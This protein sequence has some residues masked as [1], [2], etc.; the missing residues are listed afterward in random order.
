MTKVSIHSIPF[1][2]VPKFTQI[3]I[4]YTTDPAAFGDF[5]SF[6]P[7]LANFGKALSNRSAYKSERELLVEVLREQ[8]ANVKQPVERLEALLDPAHFTVVTAHQPS[9]L[10]GPMYFIYKICSTIHLARQIAQAYPAYQITPVFVIG[11]EDHDF[12]EVNHLNLFGKQYTWSTPQNGSVGRMLVDQN[13]IELLQ[14]VESTFGSAPYSAAMQK[15]I[16]S[17]FVAGKPYG[18]CMQRFVI[19]LFRDTGLIVLSMDDRRL[20]RQFA[21][22]IKE[23]LMHQTSRQL[24]EKHQAALTSLG[25][26][27]QTYQRDINL[28]YLRDGLRGR[29]VESEGIYGV[30]DTEISMT[31]DQILSEVD[32]HPERFSPNVNL[33]PLYQEVT[34]PNLAY[35]GG[36][37]ELAYWLERKTLFDHY[38]VPLPI[39]VRRNSLIYLDPFVSKQRHKLNIPPEILCESQDAWI[40]HWL[41]TNAA[42]EISIDKEQQQIAKIF[43]AIVEKAN[44]IDPTLGNKFEAERTRIIKDIEHLGKRLVRAEKSQNETRIA[45]VSKLHDKLMPGGNLQERHENFIPHFLRLGPAFLATLIEQ[46]DPFLKHVLVMEED[47]GG[48]E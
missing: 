43:E 20:K 45:Q 28:F 8:Y 6:T 19:E 41:H 33:R 29:I 10:A 1:Q 27:P 32:N 22:V 2:R 44:T 4:D 9:L 11:G 12:E 42:H 15:I 21:R 38:K 39:L 37:G 13:L 16:R 34:L 25:Y 17:A 47:S 26:K 35:V 40:S 30:V 18:E 24:I 3:D 23:E 46:L 36:G 5:I 48:T 14:Q 31:L 7:T